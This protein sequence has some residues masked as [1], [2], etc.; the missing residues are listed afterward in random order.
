MPSFDPKIQ[1]EN[2]AFDPETL[3]ACSGC[4][5]MNPPNRIDCVYCGGP[6]ALAVKHAAMVTPNLRK[7]ELWERGFNLIVRAKTLNA[8]PSSIAKYLSLDPDDVLA[9]LDAGVEIP[10]ARV[11]SDREASIVQTRLGEFGLGCMIVSDDELAAEAPPKRLSGM[12]IV[13]QVISLTD[14]NTDRTVKFDVDDFVLLVPGSISTDR[15]D[16]LEKKRRGRKTK[17]LDEIS[18]AADEMVLD[19]YTR[20]DSNGF[21]IH[22]SGFD[23][24]CLGEDK[25]LLAG[26]NLR[27]LIVRLAVVLPNAKLVNDYAAVRRVLGSVWDV[28][29]RKDSH[30]LQ[31]SGFGKVEFGSTASSSNLNQFTKFSRLQRHLV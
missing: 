14:F 26:E 20:G 2:I 30:G 29:S 10:I 6:L 22:L 19:I 23:F 15:I 27:L 11:E 8:D 17:L 25:G 18:T 1:T 31:R 16:M 3:I 12:D 13:D 5:R 21:R 4:G 28:E 7:L 24:S 9:I